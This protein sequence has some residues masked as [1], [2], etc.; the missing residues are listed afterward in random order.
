MTGNGTILPQGWRY[1]LPVWGLTLLVLI[2]SDALLLNLLLILLSFFAAYLF[3]VPNRVPLDSGSE[4]LIAP[5]DGIV[6]K[7]EEKDGAIHLQIKKRL[8]DVTAVRAP[9]D[10]DVVASEYLHGL[11]LATDDPKASRLNEQVAI[12]YRWEDMTIR[13]RIVCGFYSFGLPATISEGP[14]RT[15]ETLAVLSEGGV[16]LTLPKSLSL[17]ISSGDAVLGGQ[18]VLAR[19]TV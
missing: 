11:F 10:G 15:G 17:A 12:G 2:F 3:F 19:K 1:I 8:F 14:V 13:M 9:L 4:A 16:H 18:S 7:I 5:V 6:S